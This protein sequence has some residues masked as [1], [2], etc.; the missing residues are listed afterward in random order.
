V[1]R[2]GRPKQDDRRAGVRPDDEEDLIGSPAAHK[3]EV[4]GEDVFDEH[5][6]ASYDLRQVTAGV[7]MTWLANAFRMDVVS[8]KK[9]VADCPVKGAG[10]GRTP[11]FDLPTA[12]SYLVKPRGDMS[13]YIKKIRPNDLPPLLQTEFWDAAL[14]RQKW[15]EKAGELWPTERVL[16]TLSDA[17]KLIKETMRSW[18]D[19]IEETHGMTKGQRHTFLALVDSLQ[20]GLHKRLVEFPKQRQTPNQLAEIEDEPR[21]R[22]TGEV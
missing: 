5:A 1:A 8:V 4:I 18:H 13:E 16:D 12:A 22:N 6:K 21:P 7:S 19:T 2:H 20:D 9:R 11:L 3:E 17:F 15:Q 14:K 10:R